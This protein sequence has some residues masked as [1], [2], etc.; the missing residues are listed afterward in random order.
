MKKSPRSE[1]RKKSCASFRSL[2]CSNTLSILIEHTSSS[3]RPVNYK[4]KKRRQLTWT[5]KVD[6]RA[7][8]RRSSRMLAG[9]GI[10]STSPNTNNLC[11]PIIRLA[12]EGLHSNKLSERQGAS[13]LHKINIRGGTKMVMQL[14]DTY[15]TMR[16]MNE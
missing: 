15:K 8:S 16:K 9:S 5:R 12:K 4:K 2:R 13:S 14:Q 1:E 7:T 3:N 10:R 6:S 11:R